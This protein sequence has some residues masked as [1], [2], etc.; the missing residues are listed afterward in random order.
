MTQDLPS[1]ACRSE[2]DAF[3]AKHAPATSAS[4]LRGRLIFAI[5][6]TGSRQQTWDIAC[7]LQGE[8][9]DAVAE[10][11][12]LDAQLVFYRGRECQAS[13]RV[14]DGRALAKLM[15]TITC[16][17]G[18]TQIG[19]VLSHARRESACHKVNALVFVGDAMEETPADLYANARELNLPIFLFQEGQDRMTTQTFREIAQLT[20]GA[21]CQFNPSSPK[22]LC[23]LLRAVAIYAVGGL[24]AL[25]T[26]KNSAAAGLVQQL[27]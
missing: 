26:S 18:Y 17:S 14:S 9:F 15:T 16:C 21:Y 7:G 6:A 19:K 22:Q 12:T 13:R 10:I 27:R 20:K 8:M 23:E 5:D 25:A 4:A 3:L 24:K 2:V 11:G 1:A